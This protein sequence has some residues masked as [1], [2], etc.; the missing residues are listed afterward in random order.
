MLA[1]ESR[2]N[3]LRS[4]LVQQLGHEILFQFVRVFGRGDGIEYP[5]AVARLDLGN[6]GR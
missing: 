3:T 2:S 6:A 4:G 1:K 5:A